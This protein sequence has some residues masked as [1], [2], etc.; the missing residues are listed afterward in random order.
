MRQ[1]ET[2]IKREIEREGHKRGNGEHTH[3]DTP[4][5][6]SETRKEKVQ[7][8]K[9]EGHREASRDKIREQQKDKALIFHSQ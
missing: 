6:C 1:K 9:R 5:C 8:M 4:T 7:T 3:T 2:L